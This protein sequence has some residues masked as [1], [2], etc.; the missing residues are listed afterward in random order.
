MK[1]FIELEYVNKKTHLNIDKI[2]HVWVDRSTPRI[3][4]DGY[5]VEDA[6]GSIVYDKT[7]YATIMGGARTPDRLTKEQYEQLLE[8][9]R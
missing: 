8:M 1:Q 9:D 5:E 4:E 6:D 2:K 3:D 7:Y